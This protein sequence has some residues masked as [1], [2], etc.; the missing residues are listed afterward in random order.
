MES[1][2]SR[3]RPETLTTRGNIALAL[4]A[5]PAMFLTAQLAASGGQ[6]SDG[7]TVVASIVATLAT[8]SIAC[9]GLAVLTHQDQPTGDS[10]EVTHHPAAPSLTPSEVR[11]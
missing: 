3:T 7:H 6:W 11:K 9:H 2:V 5:P 1:A 4:A 8:A 10:P